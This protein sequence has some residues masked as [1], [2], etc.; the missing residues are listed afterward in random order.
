MTAPLL[1]APS[2][3][4]ST[5]PTGAT[6]PSRPLPPAPGGIASGICSLS[7]QNRTFRFRTNPNTI[8]WTYEL[9]KATEDTYGGRVIQLLGTKLGDLKV[10]V[11]CGNGGWAYLMSV[12]LWLR[13]LL[14]DQRQG[15][16]ATFL[17]TTRNWQLNV[18]A[19]TIPMMD[20]VEATTREIELNFK[21]QEDVSGIL[22]RLTLDTELSKLQQ[23]VC[24]PGN[25]PHNMYN[26]HFVLPGQSAPTTPVVPGGPNYTPSGITNTVDTNVTGSN[27]MG[28]NPLAGFP[29]INQIPGVQNLTGG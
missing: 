15:G 10:T 22:S 11:E 29:I 3:L 23:G 14:N 12:V 25:P 4:Q 20:K 16:T 21:I 19:M 5:P 6:A 28:L 1:I 9:I 24:G 18:Y 2:Q 13:D 8:W 26:D 7:F 17:Y 27:P